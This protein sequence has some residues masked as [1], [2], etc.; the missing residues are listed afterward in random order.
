MVPPTVMIA[1]FEGPVK[2]LII[3]TCGFLYAS[4]TKTA[5]RA[6]DYD[7]RGIDFRIVF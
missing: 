6:S 4:D 3:T 2:S 5:L 1:F 7:Y